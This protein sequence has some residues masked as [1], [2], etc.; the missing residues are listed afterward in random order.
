MYY[1]YVIFKWV[2]YVNVLVIL[3]LNVLLYCYKIS[4]NFYILYIF[5]VFLIL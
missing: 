1:Y 2:I 3:G 4:F 5:R